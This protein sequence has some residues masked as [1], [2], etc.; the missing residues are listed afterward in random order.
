MREEAEK[1]RLKQIAEEEKQIRMRRRSSPAIRQTQAVVP[2]E[3]ATFS[4]PIPHRNEFVSYSNV[5]QHVF[6]THMHS[7]LVRTC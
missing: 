2:A 1:E 3:R 7:L 5:F 4:E 6:S